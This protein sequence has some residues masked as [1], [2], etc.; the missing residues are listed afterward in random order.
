MLDTAFESLKTFDWG[1]DLAALNPIEDA[2]IAAHEKPE[3]GK[4]LESR[5]VAALQRELSLDAQEYVCRKLAMVGTAAA[6]PRLTALLIKKEISHMAR[7]ALERIPAPEAS[8]ALLDALPKVSGPVKVGVISS[9]GARRDSAAVAALGGLL[10]DSDPAIARAAA[11][12]LGAIGNA[13]S[14]VALQLAQQA[15]TGNP[16]TLIDALLSCA[17]ALLAGNKPAEASAI[18]KSFEQASQ[19]RLVRLAAA[20]GLLA[21][22]SKQA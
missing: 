1:S 22:A 13:E 6:I 12:A 7:F 2:A 21:C 14:A 16:L 3:V 19:P 4:D 9:L 10:K 18:Y 15:S 17:E 8:Q 11:L 5:L 20:R